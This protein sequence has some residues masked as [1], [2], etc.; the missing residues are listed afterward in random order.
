M[1]RTGLAC[2]VEFFR[3]SRSRDN[4]RTEC[5]PELHGRDADATSSTGDEQRLAGCEGGAIDECVDRRAVRERQRGCNIERHRIG[6]SEDR[7]VMYGDVFGKSTDLA[8]GHHAIANR[9]I[10]DALADFNDGTGDFGPRAKWKMRLILIGALHDQHVGE[11][12]S[13]T[14]DFNLY[15]CRAS[16][17]TDHLF[18]GEVCRRPPG[19]TD[20]GFHHACMRVVTRAPL[21]PHSRPRGPHRGHIQRSFRRSRG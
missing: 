17:G 5:F 4:R 1:R 20:D 11:I 7:S 6:Y 19:T 9:E 2:R 12:D 15:G 14:S 3:R 13:R 10:D 8:D 18:D 16:R 21:C